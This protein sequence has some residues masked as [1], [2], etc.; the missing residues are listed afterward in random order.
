MQIDDGSGMGQFPFG[1]GGEEF[2][3]G[4]YGEVEEDEDGESLSLLSSHA[5]LGRCIAVLNCDDRIRFQP[6][7]EAQNSIKMEFSILDRVGSNLPGSWVAEFYVSN[8]GRK[9]TPKL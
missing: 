2:G 6:P 3:D 8:T 9:V 4:E 1:I 5:P 7:K